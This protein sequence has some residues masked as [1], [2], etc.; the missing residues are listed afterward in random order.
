MSFK[1]FISLSWGKSAACSQHT[2]F[3]HIELCHVFYTHVLLALLISFPLIETPFFISF[4]SQFMLPSRC[5]SNS[6]VL[7]KSSL[8]QPKQEASFPC[9]FCAELCSY[10]I[11]KLIILY[12][13][14]LLMKLFST[15]GLCSFRTRIMS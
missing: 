6:K 10:A 14:Y 4:K 13:H 5:S 8:K 3:S 11:I 12:H 1:P 2:P 15:L 9:V 7:V